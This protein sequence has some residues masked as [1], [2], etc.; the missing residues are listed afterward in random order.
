[1]YCENGVVMFV[2]LSNHSS[3]YW[4]DNQIAAAK[5]YGKIVDIQF[6]V[7]DASGDENYIN[8]LVAEWYNRIIELA[9]DGE[10]ELVVHIMG[11]SCFTYLLVSRLLSANIRCV[12]STT[13]RDVVYNDGKKEVIFDFIRFREYRKWI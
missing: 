3:E 4:N 11:E 6:P 13:N 2:N 12:A 5:R 10:E 9:A 7:I 1:M 8:D